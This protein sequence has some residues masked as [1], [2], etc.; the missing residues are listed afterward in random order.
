MGLLLF[1]SMA[2]FLFS[3]SPILAESFVAPYSGTLYIRC[4]GGS[5][6]ATSDFG[7]GTN[8]SDWTPYLRNLPP[9]CPTTEIQI[10]N[11]TAGQVVPF[12]MRTQWLGKE[13]WAFSTA[14]DQASTTAFS[15]T[16]NSL[17]WGGKII[18][19][20]DPD[21]WVMHLDDAASYT[22]DDND[23]DFLIQIRLVR[24][25]RQ[26]TQN[27]PS[28]ETELVDRDAS[29]NKNAS[30]PAVVSFVAVCLF[31]FSIPAQQAQESTVSDPEA[32]AV[33]AALIPQEYPIRREPQKPVVLQREAETFPAAFGSCFPQNVGQDW[34]PV[35]DSYKAEN[36]NSRVVIPGQPLRLV[37]SVAPKSSLGRDDTYIQ[38]S[39]VGFNAS[40]TRAMVYVAFHCGPKCAGGAHHFVEKVG[41]A[42]REAALPNVSQCGWDS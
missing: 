33:Y 18:E 24:A 42:W 32:Y 12:A 3:P 15:D 17:K 31:P 37:Y 14:Q 16:D 25:R 5:A 2:M 9:S 28:T 34:Q 7:T 21:T 4:I 26:V 23:A 22:V 35:V 27:F 1:S 19:Q 30:I 20:T 38:V 40:K 6:G 13:Y 10:G 39:A 8:L 36:T 11:V 29:M 41:G